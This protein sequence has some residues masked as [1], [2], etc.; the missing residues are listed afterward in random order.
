[1]AKITFEKAKSIMEDYI[2]TIFVGDD[3]YIASYERY[4]NDDDIAQLA[5]ITDE[6]ACDQAIARFVRNIRK[7]SI[8]HAYA[9]AIRSAYIDAAEDILR[10]VKEEA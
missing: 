6:D 7:S 8:A 9:N 1:M 4:I 2:Y 5:C 3:D 10:R